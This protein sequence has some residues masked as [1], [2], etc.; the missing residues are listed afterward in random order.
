MGTINLTNSILNV[1]DGMS[2]GRDNDNKG[3]LAL[4]MDGTSQLNFTGGGIEA[5]GGNNGGLATYNMALT[6][7]FHPGGGQVSLRDGINV[8]GN[9]NNKIQ[10]NVTSGSAA[11]SMYAGSLNVATGSSA[12]GTL[13]VDTTD[14][15]FSGSGSWANSGSSTALV[16]L[17]NGA[18]LDML[19]GLTMRSGATTSAT[20]TLTMNSGSLS[21]LDGGNGFSMSGRVVDN[22]GGVLNVDYGTLSSSVTGTGN[23]G[24]GTAASP[25][26]S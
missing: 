17:T 9:Q 24:Q 3:Y 11:Q 18:E 5:G 26:G 2:V 16:N 8:A 20:N 12:Q 14:M 25:A 15:Q 23:V 22:T 21:R 7:A 19:G 6:D 1:R 13:N 10:L 4:T